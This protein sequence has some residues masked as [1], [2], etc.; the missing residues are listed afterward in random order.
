MIE[1]WLVGL[2]LALGGCVTWF[3]TSRYYLRR[4]DVMGV[5]SR[6]SSARDHCRACPVSGR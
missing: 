6:R 3:A 4:M 2:A 1:M 5:E